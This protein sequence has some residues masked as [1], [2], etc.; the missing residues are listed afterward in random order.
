MV[1]PAGTMKHLSTAL[2]SLYRGQPS[3][4]EWVVA[5]LEGAWP[6]IMGETLARK[7]RPSI[8]DRGVLTIEVTDEAWDAPLREMVDQL[9]C[10]LTQATAGEVRSVV[11]TSTKIT[12]A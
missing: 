8:F 11:M 7:C 9:R 4:G 3:H 10:R 6:A 5:C 2:Y 1:D 12:K